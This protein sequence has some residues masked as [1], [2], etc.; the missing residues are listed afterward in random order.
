MKPVA[1]MTGF[2]S[3]ARP[4]ALGQLT[5]DLRSVNSRFLDL[6]MRIWYDWRV[7]EPMLREAIAGAPQPR[8]GGMPDQHRPRRGAA[9]PTLNAAAL[10]QL[11]GL[12]GQVEQAIPGVRRLATADVPRRPGVVETPGS[13]PEALR[14]ATAEALA[15]ALDGMTASRRR[16][17]EALREA[18]IAHCTQVESIANQLKAR[19]PD[20]LAP[21]NASCSSASNR[22]SARR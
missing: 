14:A 9:E 3:A 2:A 11:T 22:R 6:S 12:A 18:L 20:L 4:T 8:Q 17:G 15:E 7:F 13:D 5:I 19:A 10:A 1:S 16:E 21:S